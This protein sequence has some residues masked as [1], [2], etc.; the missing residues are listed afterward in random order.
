MA[1]KASAAQIAARKAFKERTVLAKQI[2]ETS[3]KGKKGK[4]FADAVKAA[5]KKMK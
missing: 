1:K 5:S 3:M 2:W 4:T